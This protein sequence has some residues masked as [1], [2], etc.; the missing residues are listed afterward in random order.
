MNRSKVKFAI[1]YG[2]GGLRDTTRIAASSAEMWRDICLTNRTA[3]LGAP[4]TVFAERFEE[5]E[6]V[7]E[8]AEADELIALF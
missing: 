6:R 8:R 3:I 1:E 2:A 5:F 4:E 7:V